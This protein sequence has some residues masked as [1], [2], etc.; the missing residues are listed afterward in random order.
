M[1]EIKLIL[2]FHIFLRWLCTWVLVSLMSDYCK[3]Y[4]LYTLWHSNEDEREKKAQNFYKYAIVTNL[5]VGAIQIIENGK[6]WNE[7]TKTSIRSNVVV[8]MFKSDLFNVVILLH[9]FILLVSFILT[10]HFFSFSFFRFPF[11]CFVF[12]DVRNDLL[13]PF[14]HLRFLQRKISFISWIYFCFCTIIILCVC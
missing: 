9:S 13:N 8:S 14:C 5:L 1:Q 4:G 6:I 11:F 7:H 2:Q 12:C 3:R 10:L